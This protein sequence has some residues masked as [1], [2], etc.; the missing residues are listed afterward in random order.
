MVSETS[1]FGTFTAT[2]T[3]QGSSSVWG[4]VYNNGAV[5]EVSITCQGTTV[6]VERT[7]TDGPSQG[8]SGY[9]DGAFAPGCDSVSGT[10]WSHSFGAVGTSWSARIS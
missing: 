8:A 9:Y 2:W 5:V 1:Q 6:H 3:R 10:T 7:D 4:G